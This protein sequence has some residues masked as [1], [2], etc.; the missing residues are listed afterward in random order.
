MSPYG[1]SG[2]ILRVDLTT[3]RIWTEKTLEKYRDYLGA[4]GIGYKVMWD[5]V[6]AGVGAFDPENRIV[7]GG[8][9]LI[10]TG[11]PCGGRVAITSLLPASYPTEVIGS[12]HMGGH[13]GSELKFAGWDAVIIQ[14]KAPRPVWLAIDDD[15]VEIRDARSFWGS[16]IYR[17]TA[18]IC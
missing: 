10:G 15:K 4:T 11:S 12:G 14:G 8:G 13:W 16:G 3:G 9:P 17:A 6:P 2:K 1:W 18:E 5:E 7:F